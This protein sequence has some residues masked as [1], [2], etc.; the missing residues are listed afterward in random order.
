VPVEAV[1]GGEAAFECAAKV[2]AKYAER[3]IRCHV[4]SHVTTLSPEGGEIPFGG[5]GLYERCLALTRDLQ[6]EAIIMVIQEDELLRTGLPVD[7]ID[8]ISMAGE[9]APA[10][11]E[12]LLQL[13]RRYERPSQAEATEPLSQAH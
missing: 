7:Q 1:L 11:M 5:L 4:T 3:G 2:Q 8:G 6:V 10:W 12:A 9:S 13:L